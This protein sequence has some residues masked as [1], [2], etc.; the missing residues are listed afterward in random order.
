MRPRPAP[1]RRGR[2]TITCIGEAPPDLPVWS[3]VARATWFRTRWLDVVLRREDE[4]WMVLRAD[5]RHE[6]DT[7]DGPPIADWRPHL[8]TAFEAAGLEVARRG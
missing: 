8:E 4:G 6:D 2:I 3:A 5:E 1:L 7:P